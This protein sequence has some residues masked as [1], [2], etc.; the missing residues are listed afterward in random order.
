MRSPTSLWAEPPGMPAS[1]GAA[2]KLNPGSPDA[3]IEF[4]S[5]WKAARLC[6]GE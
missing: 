2:I 6:G 5:S 1:F 3:H 4:G